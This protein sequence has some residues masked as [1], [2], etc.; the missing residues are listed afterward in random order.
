MK[1]LESAILMIDILSDT[2][3][4]QSKDLVAINPQLVLKQLE[5][6]SEKL[7]TANVKVG[8]ILKIEDLRKLR[9]LGKKED[10]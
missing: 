6:I 7:K 10:K 9:K 2:V 8:K 4:M 3:S 5:K 1:E